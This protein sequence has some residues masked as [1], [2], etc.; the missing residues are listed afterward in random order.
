MPGGRIKQGESIS[1]ATERIAQEKHKINAKLEKINSIS[2]EYTYK[3]KK[4]KEKIHSF[5]LI[6]VTASTKD[7][8]E[9]INVSKNK[10][11]IIT[12]DYTLVKKDLNKEIQMREFWTED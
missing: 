6:F 11:K 8:V 9:Y 10:S 7:E 4:E 12:S 3:N 2:I 1:K 5:L